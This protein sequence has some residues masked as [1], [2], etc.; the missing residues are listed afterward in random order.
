[1]GQELEFDL[2]WS[3]RSP[4][5]YLAT[6]R[7]RALT[8]DYAVTAHLRPVYPTAVRDPEAL[9][10]KGP[11]WLSYFRLDITREAERLG[12]PLA[13]PRPDPVAIEPSGALSSEQPR[14]ERLTR[15][16]VAA[17]E[18]DA[19]LAFACEVGALLWNPNT[20]D[21]TAPGLLEAAATR[22]GLDLKDLDNAIK[23]DPDHYEKVVQ[24]NQRAENAAG[25][26]GAPVMV[27][28]GEPFFGQDRIDSLIWR[29]HQTGLTPRT[30]TRRQSPS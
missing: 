12:L 3:F 8:R 25:H 11:L 13:W 1:M 2:Y 6:S 16:G 10:A 30:Q 7:L 20:E 5:C 24:E 9:A 23:T 4:Y 29:L 28:K 17:E 27:Y 21:W 22:A 18:R 19:G 14:I 15:L 26:W